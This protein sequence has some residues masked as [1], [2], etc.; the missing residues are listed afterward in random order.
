MPVRASPQGTTRNAFHAYVFPPLSRR[1][2]VS[3]SPVVPEAY[4][5]E[6]TADHAFGEKPHSSTP[7]A[8]RPTP[9][10]ATTY[11]C[12]QPDSYIFS[13]ANFPAMHQGAP[14][15]RGMPTA[16]LC[17]LT[18]PRRRL[19]SPPHTHYY[20]ITCVSPGLSMHRVRPI[21]PVLHLETSHLLRLRCD[22]ARVVIRRGGRCGKRLGSVFLRGFSSLRALYS[23]SRDSANVFSSLPC[24]S[25][26]TRSGVVTQQSAIMSVSSAGT[27]P[28]PVTECCLVLPV[29]CHQKRGAKLLSRYHKRLCKRS[30][31]CLAVP[32]RLRTTNRVQQM[33]VVPCQTQAVEDTA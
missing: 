18:T 4:V 32:Q 9:L 20:C 8:E 7:L 5:S 10:V 29:A 1:T 28:R 12:G 17:P 27:V 22:L 31:T 6:L 2:Y 23:I 24:A 15:S 26:T 14:I 33:S 3:I 13:L 11:T 19:S 16:P 25:E 30:L 21:T